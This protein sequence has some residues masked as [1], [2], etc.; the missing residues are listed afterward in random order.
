MSR[1]RF[2]VLLVAVLGLIALACSESAEGP[3]DDSS[4]SGEA[5]VSAGEP[6]GEEPEAGP[7]P[8][9]E[10]EPAEPDSPES[11]PAEQDAPEPEPVEPAPAEPAPAEQD[12][13]GTEPVEPAPVEQEP[14][15][16]QPAESGFPATITS[17]GGTWTLES[18]PERIVSL[19]PAATEILFAIGAGGQV[20]AVDSF[21]N[22]PP[23]APVTDLSAYDP[24]VEAVTAF[25]PD[26][27]V[28]FYDANDLVAGLSALGIPV[29]VIPAPAGIEDGYGAM[30]ELGQATGRADEAAAAINTMRSEIGAALAAAPDRAVRIY[31]ELDE[32][33]YS[34][35]SSGFVG[36]VYTAL[37]ATNIA[38][39]AD[40][41][42]YGFPQLTEEYIVEADPELIV[43]TNHASYTVTD[44]AA[45]P[46]WEQV[47]AVRNGNIVVVEA[48]VASRWGPRL[49]RFVAA[50]AE[51]LSSVVA[52]AAG[53]G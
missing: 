21:S 1:V 48:D 35:S 49:P 45:R 9:Q 27:V 5:A 42:G 7:E 47:T 53:T 20:V 8:P 15:E 52:A 50:V 11:A 40:G 31:H 38:D 25:D 14:T 22:H 2:L 12:G 32:S 33:Y 26:L 4:G 17:D 23:E 39:E 37:G 24:N 36:A 29:L 19:S 51:A 3:G 18:A 10:T 41:G 46:G 16:P 30:V 43:I 13:A 6:R 28:I 34:A 44:V